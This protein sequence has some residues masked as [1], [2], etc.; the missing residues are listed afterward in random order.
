VP[1]RKAWTAIA[2]CLGILAVM[3]TLVAASL[4]YLPDLPRSPKT[5]TG[6]VYAVRNHY[7]VIYWNKAELWT[8]RLLSAIAIGLF[9]A[10]FLILWHLG[11]LAW[12]K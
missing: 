6:H 9:G 8:N 5:D 11:L 10:T 4:Y 7:T 3:C 1:S 2:R 12:R